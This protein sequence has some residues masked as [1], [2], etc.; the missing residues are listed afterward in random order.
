MAEETKGEYV[1]EYVDE[2]KDTDLTISKIDNVINEFNWDLINTYFKDNYYNLV[3]HHLNSFNKFFNIDIYNIFKENNPIKCV[4][5]NA[6][7]S[8]PNACLLYLGGKDGTKLYFGKPIIYDANNA[9][10][11]Y[12]NDA[13][14]RNMTYGVTVHYDV[15][16]EYLSYSES[17]DVTITEHSLP[18]IYLGKFPIMLHSD[19][20]ILK[21]LHKNAAFNMG[22]CRNDVGG[23]FII[24][25]KEKVIVS[26]EKF[27]DNMLYVRKNK[28]DN[29][30]SYSADIRSVSEDASKPVRVT[31]IKILAPS[32]ALTNNQILVD[33]PNVKK[34]IPLFIVMRALGVISDRSIIEYCLLDIEKY[35]S[36]IDLFIPSIHDA[37]QIFTQDTALLFITEFTKYKKISSVLEI[38]SNYFLPHIGS[39]NFLDKAYFI[40]HM[41][42]KMLKVFTKDDLPTDRDNFV[43][44]RIETSGSLIYDLFRE[45]FLIQQKNIKLAIDTKYLFNRSSESEK[46]IDLILKN[47]IDIFST[48]IVDDGFKKAFKGNWGASAHTK[49]IGVIQ[50]LNRLSWYSFSSHL[51][52]VNLPLDSTSKVIKPRLLNS[53]QWGYIDPVDTPDGGNI[54]LHKHLSITT[55]ITIGYSSQPLIEFLFKNTTLKKL[56]ECRPIDLSFKTKVFVNGNWIGIYD[57]FDQF[58]DGQYNNSLYLVSQLKLLRR[59]GLIPIY[60]SIS[61]NYKQ[62]A[63]YLYTDGGRLSRPIYYIEHNKCSISLG[64]ENVE[65]YNTWNKIVTGILPKKNYDINKNIL[66]TNMSDLYDGINTADF[67][68]KNNDEFYQRD[69]HNNFGD[70]IMFGKS[71]ADY[72]E[73]TEHLDKI[74]KCATTLDNNKSIIDYIDT[75]EEETSLI[76]I[77]YEALATNKFYTH[78]EIDPSLIFGVMGN[79]VIFPETNPVTRDAFSC[80]QSKQAVSVYHSNYQMRMDK[81]GVVLNY[82]QTPLI[83]SR[84]LK[85]IYNEEHPYGINAI[86]AIMS[87]TGY[88]VEDAILVNKSS[89]DRGMFKTTYLTTY[90]AREESST[91]KGSASDSKFTKIVGKQVSGINPAYNYTFLDDSGI[92]EENTFINDEKTVLIGKVINSEDRQT[93][94]DE[95]VVSKK[96]QFGFVDKSFITD[97]EEGFRIAK[98]RV[99]ED[100]IPAIGDKMASRA[101][102][103]G[104]IG[105][106]IPEEN[107]PFTAD[108]IRPDIIIN[109]HAIPSRMTLSQL[110]ETLFGKACVTYGASGDGTAFVNKGF[111]LKLYGDLLTKQGFHSSGNQ[112]LY[113]GMSGEQISSE[114][115]IGPT[116]YM[117]IKQMVKDKINFRARGPRTGLTRQSVQGRANDGGLRIGEMERD[118][119]ISHGA[120]TFLTESY[121]T[122]GDE[123]F[124]AVCNKTGCIA[125]YN[126]SIN[127]F[128]SPCADGPLKF[129]ENVEGS[130]IL[131]S[132]S[133]FGRSFSILRVPY[134]LKLLIQ[135]LQTMNIQLRIITDDNIDQMMNLSYTPSMRKELEVINQQYKDRNILKQK[136]LF[137]S[138]GVAA[139]LQLQNPNN[140]PTDSVSDAIRKLLA[141]NPIKQF[142]PKSPIAIPEYNQDNSPA[143]NPVS[144]EYNSDA[145]P[146]YVPNSQDNQPGS[147]LSSPEYNSDASQA[148]VPNSQDYQSASPLVSP[149]N[150]PVNSPAFNPDSPNLVGGIKQFNLDQ[151]TVKKLNSLSI[152]ELNKLVD[153]IKNKNKKS[154]I[155]NVAEKEKEKEKESD[156]SG[157]K[158]ITLT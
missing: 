151:E 118:S 108:G 68:I 35:E 15:D 105:L 139:P 14:L 12:P 85:Y 80:G 130:Q 39:I 125:V 89:L 3:T 13:R 28:S 8:T 47:P 122:R 102:Q 70:L 135:E 110:I 96:G 148:Y 100:R 111:D 64:I 42:F 133:R 157:K 129:N 94:T 66:Y 67:F 82:G 22:E 73:F 29:K 60:T 101:G 26:Q 145:S 92:V 115:F 69:T 149:V 55:L 40:G 65:K 49:R 90:E 4:E 107:M 128:L 53:S 81:M 144:P 152:D 45:Y 112:L 154:S 95:S 88:N 113:N 87:F 21:G 43:F 27:A 97:G 126:S 140:M 84:Y 34:P 114:I 1:D 59:N 117:R 20:C 109:P 119:I 76:A 52:K 83:K 79:S 5:K 98:V 131:N 31:S 32:P 54:G 19:L 37:S 104:T 127:L 138:T 10:F 44:K 132:V 62:N 23:Y 63:I 71:D 48:K 153:N 93:M 41:V 134:A 38:L 137:K 120:S 150:S 141:N 142:K 99:R 116:Y 147:P 61:F 30:Y 86:V 36:Y 77:N 18:N 25:G 72:R 121:L 58:R 2:Y 75:A 74:T 16:V 155:L 78:L 143:F 6:N 50:D 91:I 123:Y 33:I 158:I 24:E 7:K 56:Q 106:I 9:H 103:K 51:R 124:M 57:N 136:I 17:G 11:M 46:L 146:A 156:N